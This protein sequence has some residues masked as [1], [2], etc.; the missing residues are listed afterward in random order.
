MPDC[1]R[2]S[3]TRDGSTCRSGGVGARP[4]AAAGTPAR[5][6]T[7]YTEALRAIASI[8]VADLRAILTGVLVDSLISSGRFDDARSATAL[9]PDAQRR[10]TALGAVAES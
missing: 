2:A 10:L 1:S 7:V 6:T 5:A 3:R 9:F 8:P 4:R